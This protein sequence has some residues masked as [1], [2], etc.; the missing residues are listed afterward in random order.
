MA[1]TS[2]A[3]KGV[4]DELWNHG[5]RRVYVYVSLRGREYAAA[6]GSG[7]PRTRDDR[8]RIGDVSETFAAAIVLQLAEEG[9]LR[10]YDSLAKYVRGVDRLER[11]IT[12]LQLLSNTSGLADYYTF[13]FWLQ[14]ANRLNTVRPVDLLKAAAFQPRGFK[15]PGSSFS[16]S[17]TNYIALGLVVEKVTGHPYNEELMRRIVRPLGLSGTELA[18]TP[19]RIPGRDRGPGINPN[20]FWAASGIVSTADD[21]AKFYSA[22]LSGRLV[23]RASLN[24]MERT[25]QDPAG[26]ERYGLG[27]LAFDLSCGSFWGQTDRFN[28]SNLPGTTVTASADGSRVAIVL[29]RGRSDRSPDMTPLL[30]H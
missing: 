19:I 16:Y 28:T 7:P 22:L 23:S 8:V 4:A 13:G 9:K 2:P 6:A 18:S 26:P 14:R 5:A 30:C 11:G 25:V 27:L 3:V 20:L 29:M 10:L 17:H 24:K 12:L 15:R 21:L 1:A